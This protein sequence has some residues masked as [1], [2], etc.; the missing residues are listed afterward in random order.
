MY[1]G[2]KQERNSGLHEG[3]GSRIRAQQSTKPNFCDH[4]PEAERI[5]P[6]LSD[7]HTR[8]CAGHS[9]SIAA[10]GLFSSVP[11]PLEIF[12]AL[13]KLGHHYRSTLEDLSI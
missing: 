7:L 5:A 12:E 13:L 2:G 9:W 8:R 10:M 4:R 3:R 6:T 11:R 1:T